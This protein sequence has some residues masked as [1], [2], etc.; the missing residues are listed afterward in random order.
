MYH[1]AQAE[2]I[3]YGFETDFQLLLTRQ[4]TLG[5]QSEYV[6]AEQLSGDKKG[7]SLPF[8]PPWSAN[9]RI[10]YH[11]GRGFWGENGDILLEYKV[12]GS[13]DRIVPPEEKT[14]GYQLLN[15]SLGSNWQIRDYGIK[16]RLQLQNLL[17]KR[18][19]D[20]TGFYRLIDVPEPGR[21]ISA[22]LG[23]TF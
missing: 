15:L 23:F 8:S 4:F 7:Y 1:Y 20:H 16:L 21:N 18:Y 22:L 5:I 10:G 3:R 6:Y 19:Y 9:F 12:T 11:P 2:V 17:N 13:Q 14:D